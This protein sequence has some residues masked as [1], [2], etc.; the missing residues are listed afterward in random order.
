MLILLKASH[1]FSP[2]S[3]ADN[4]LDSWEMSRGM[5]YLVLAGLCMLA[6]APTL[7]IPLLEDDFPNIVQ[8][9]SYGSWDGLGAL[10][11]DSTFRLRATSY[12]AMNWL[13]S[14]FGVSAVPFHLFSLGLHIVCTWLVYRLALGWPAMR[15]GAL[16]AAGFFAIHEGH[17]EAV[18][19]F[20]AINELLQFAFGIAAL[21]CWRAAVARGDW[22]QHVAGVALFAMALISKESAVILLPLFVLV[23]PSDKRW[24]TLPQLAPYALLAGVAVVSVLLSRGESFRFDDGSF[25]L[26][27]PFWVTM[28]HSLFRLAWIWGIPALGLLLWKRRDEGLRIVGS[29]TTWAV[30]AFLP[31]MFL[32]YS[33]SIPS[34]QTYLASVGLALLCGAAISR[35]AEIRSRRAVTVLLTIVLVHNCALLWAR[36]CGQFLDRAEPTAQLIALANGMNGDIWVRCF[37][38]PPIV[39]EAAVELAAPDYAGRLIWGA[40]LTGSDEPAAVF[41]FEDR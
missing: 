7:T 6:Y 10:A 23:T 15:S 29:A 31:Y 32:T 11:A 1:S 37:P 5:T 24:R 12:W 26:A 8:S 18:M 35:F 41:C 4:H 22:R 34:R 36:K 40:A 30:I 39:A 17:Q 14:N 20:S 2:V 38:R 9:Q 19:W 25:S 3:Q 27:A 33:T 13:W 28:P 16:W 21:L